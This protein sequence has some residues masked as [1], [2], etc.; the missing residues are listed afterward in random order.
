MIPL[1]AVSRGDAPTSLV[2]DLNRT[3]QVGLAGIAKEAAIIRIRPLLSRVDLLAEIPADVG[4]SWD[5]GEQMY[6]QL[7]KQRFLPAAWMR[8]LQ[9]VIATLR[10]RHPT[11][12]LDSVRDLMLQTAQTIRENNKLQIEHMPEAGDIPVRLAITFARLVSAYARGSDRSIATA[13]DVAKAAEFLRVKLDFLKL[14]GP[15]VVDTASVPPPHSKQQSR[16]DWV[17]Q[18][19]QTPIKPKELKE[20]YEA[21]TGESVSEKTIKRD[22]ENLSAKKVA[23]GTFVVPTDPRDEPAT[24]GDD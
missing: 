12:D 9:V 4:R 13:D 5:V 1:Q 23:T 15:D 10:D 17:A 21:E 22:L 20:H 19:A 6:G 24:R 18:N 16:Q 2:I 8:P 14:C 7:G 11:I 3:A